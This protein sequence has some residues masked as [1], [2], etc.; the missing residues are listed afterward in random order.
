[1]AKRGRQKTA[2]QLLDKSEKEQADTEAAA[3]TPRGKGGG[4]GKGEAPPSLC[5]VGEGAVGA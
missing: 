1:V 5:V 2:M 4:G 3:A